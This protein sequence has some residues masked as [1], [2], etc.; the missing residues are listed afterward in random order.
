MYGILLS[1]LFTALT[2]FVRSILVKFVVF[3][4]LYFIGAEFM[5]YLAPKLPGSS[6]LSQAFGAI[7]PGIW[8]FF[9]LFKVG[10]GVQLCLSAYVTRFAIRRMPVVG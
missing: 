8:Y 10:T 2:W 3:F 6:S 7:P 5:S 1:A 4:A 9:D